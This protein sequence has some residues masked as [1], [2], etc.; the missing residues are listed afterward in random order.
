LSTSCIL[1]YHSDR[2]KRLATHLLQQRSFYPLY[3][4]NEEMTNVDYEKMESHAQIGV[5]PHVLV[6]PS[7][8]MH[9]Y[10][11]TSGVVAINP[12]RLT[13]REGGGVFARLRIRPP[14]EGEE[15]EEEAFGKRLAGDIVRI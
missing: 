15:V 14:K 9:F 6:L 7:D 12:G 11:E 8:L 10:K 13:K 1:Q 4:P 5:L 2:L 3:P